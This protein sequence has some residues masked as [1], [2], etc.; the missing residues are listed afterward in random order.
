MKYQ[1]II[2]AAPKTLETV[3]DTA[4]REWFRLP[5]SPMYWSCS[6]SELVFW[7]TLLLDYGPV[8]DTKS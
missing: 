3:W 7:D 5:E 8:S 4:G 1:A 2:P 6:G